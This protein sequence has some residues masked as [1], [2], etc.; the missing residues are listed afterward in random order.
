[1]PQQIRVLLADDVA[2]LRTMVRIALEVDGRFRVVGEACDGIE[3]VELANSLKPDIVVL[4]ISMPNMDGLEAIPEIH[5]L[6]PGS[7]ILVL[8]GFD[9]RVGERA[10]ALS[11]DDYM[12]KTE[13]IE[14]LAAK[15]LSVLRMAPKRLG[16]TPA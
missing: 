3:A 8:S 10:V 4:D 5:R 16:Q 14:S 6:S 12:P 1:M 11:A 9:Q 13:H 7:R 15:L 2:D